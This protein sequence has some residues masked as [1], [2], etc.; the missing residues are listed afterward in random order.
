MYCFKLKNNLL[1]DLGTF[2]HIEAEVIWKK[3]RSIQR[4]AFEVFLPFQNSCALRLLFFSSYSLILPF[5]SLFN[6]SGNM[7]ER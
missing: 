6:F 4:F 7:R 5:W 2:D 3:H 1:G